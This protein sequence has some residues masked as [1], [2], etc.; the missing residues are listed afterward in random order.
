[1]LHRKGNQDA[2][3][4]RKNQNAK[5]KILTQYIYLQIQSFYYSKYVKRED[6]FRLKLLFEKIIKRKRSYL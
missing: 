5:I 4:I 1:M 3:P 6:I 2:K